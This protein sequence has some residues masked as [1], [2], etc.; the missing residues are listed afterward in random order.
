MDMGRKIPCFSVEMIEVGGNG[1][2]AGM[3]GHM[4]VNVDSYKIT[5]NQSTM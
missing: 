3:L 4:E 5:E 2:N 1:R